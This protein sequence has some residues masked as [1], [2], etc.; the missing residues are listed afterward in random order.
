MNDERRRTT[1]SV[2]LA[3][4]LA[5]F[6]TL[7]LVYPVAYM[8]RE[9]FFED[10]ALTFRHMALLFTSPMAAQAL[11]NSLLL[12]VL[13]TGLTPVLTLHLAHVFNRF[14]LTGRTLLNSLLLAP[15]IMPPFVGGS[16]SKHLMAR[17]GSLKLFLIELGLVDPSRPIDWLG[18]GG[19]WGLVIL[20]VLHLCPIMFLSLSTAVGGVD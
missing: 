11:T 2:L 10:G 4:A 18:A 15:L 1:G 14:A 17:Y 12:A 13:T 5:A 8:L 19:L 16:G 6:F 3:V 20:Q 7:F 9:A